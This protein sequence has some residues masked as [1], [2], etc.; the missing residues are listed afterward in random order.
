MTV[1][2]FTV[3]VTLVLLAVQ[4]REAPSQ[5]PDRTP[6]PLVVALDGAEPAFTSAREGVRFDLDG[7]GVAEQTAWTLPGRLEAFVALDLNRNGRIDGG[8]ELVGAGGFGPPNG[9]AYLAAEDGIRTKDEHS[10]RTMRGAPDGVIDAGDLVF[11]R[12][13]LWTDVNHDG[14][15]QESELQSAS[16]AR[17]TS[18]DLRSE[19]AGIADRHGNR[20][21]RRS[22][23]TILDRGGGLLLVPMVSVRLAV[24]VD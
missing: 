11:D 18:L 5:P 9:F 13:V 4:T 1:P 12:L 8:R 10:R 17:V 6:V 16:Y 3:A 20:L 7:D 15:S 21:D 24:S 14:L 19:V 2:R 22:V 23:A